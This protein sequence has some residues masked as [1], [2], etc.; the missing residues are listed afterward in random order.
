MQVNELMIGNWVRLVKAY[1]NQCDL[2][3]SV[4]ALDI[5][6]I[7]QGD[8]EV[9]PVALTPEILCNNGF[10]EEMDK[11]K[12]HH[13]YSLTEGS[14]YFSVKYARSVFQWLGP[15]DIE[16]VHEL[17]NVLKICGINTGIIL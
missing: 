3:I 12:I 14:T 6:R 2:Q 4:D 15:L 13:R 7:S 10:V 5:Y 17:Q 8:Y 11:D 9:E 1:G 16:Y